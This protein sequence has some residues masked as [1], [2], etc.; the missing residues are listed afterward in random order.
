[1]LLGVYRPGSQALLELFFDELSAVFE[2]L[3]AYNCPVV[4]C[5]DFNVHVDHIDDVNAVRLEQLLQSFGCIQHVTEPT[6]NAGHT[7]DIVITRNDTEIS[8]LRV[9]AMVSDH[10][11]LRFRLCVRKSCAKTLVVTSRAWRRLSLDA[12]M[13]YLAASPLCFDL[14]A[15]NDQHVDDVVKLY[16]VS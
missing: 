16:R 4:A 6:H 13:A 2:R 7:L 3:L 10:A 12:F 5:G 11:L 9:G 8:D 1:V 14:A 15:F